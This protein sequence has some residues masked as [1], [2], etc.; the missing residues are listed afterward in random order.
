MWCDLFL[1]ITYHY[2]CVG[3]RIIFLW[4]TFK[5]GASAEEEEPFA[6]CKISG[7]DAQSPWAK[8]CLKNEP[9]LRFM[10]HEKLRLRQ[11]P[12]YT[13]LKRSIITGTWGQFR[14]P[15]PLWKQKKGHYING[16]TI[17]KD[18]AVVCMMGYDHVL[19]NK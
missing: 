12:T 14:P 15:P 2:I 6:R 16:I 11:T 4:Q 10:R 19:F 13:L 3:S 8:F 5:Q 17:K 1:G 7:R 18:G 9:K